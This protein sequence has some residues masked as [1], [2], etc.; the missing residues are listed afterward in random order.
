VI[1]PNTGLLV[2]QVGEFVS[3]WS[4]VGHGSSDW[5]SRTRQSDRP[6]LGR[7]SHTACR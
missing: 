2:V 5:R 6:T 1:L 3:S 4:P 7:H